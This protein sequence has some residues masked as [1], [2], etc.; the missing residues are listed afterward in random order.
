MSVTIAALNV[1][2]G[3]VVPVVLAVGV[4]VEAHP[5]STVS[6]IASRTSSAQTERKLLFTRTTFPYPQTSDSYSSWYP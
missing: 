6:A 1:E 3:G 4:E 2:A 5:P